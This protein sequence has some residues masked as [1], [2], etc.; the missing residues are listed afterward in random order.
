M[1]FVNSAV[2]CKGVA[3]VRVQLELSAARLDWKETA[4]QLTLTMNE[5]PRLPHTTM[6]L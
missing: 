1:V 3:D 5:S 2:S 4:R 6:F